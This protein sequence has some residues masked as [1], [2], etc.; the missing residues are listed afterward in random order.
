MK[1]IFIPCLMALALVGASCSNDEIIEQRQAAEIAYA[2]SVAMAT[3]GVTTTAN[4]GEYVI[5]G[6]LTTD[7]KKTLYVDNNTFNLTGGSWTT[8]ATYFWPYTGSLD[9]YAYSP[10]KAKEKVV[11]TEEDGVRKAVIKDYEVSTLSSN[12]QDLLY[13]YTPDKSHANGADLMPVPV[14]FKHALSQV[15]FNIKNTNPALIVDVEEIR[16]ANLASKGSYTLPDAYTTLTGGPVGSWNLANKVAGGKTYDAYISGVNGITPESDVVSLS[17][18][19]NGAMLLLP[20]TTTAWDPQNDAENEA[21]GSFF[22]VKCRVW[23]MIAG[24]KTLLWPNT[25]N[26]AGEIIAREVAIPVAINWEQGKR[27]TYTLVFGEGAGYIPPTDTEP[28]GEINLGYG[29]K[30]LKPISYDVKV[31]DFEEGGNYTTNSTK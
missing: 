31:G 12:Y 16:I 23:A 1:K 6:F 24:E 25:T 14:N 10:I 8:N 15:V 20:Q 21:F 9:F 5:D 7:T 22:L 2:P 4:I 3:R 30:V 18:S 29:D 28:G 19:E 11:Y 27:Y 26:T 17:S 13:A